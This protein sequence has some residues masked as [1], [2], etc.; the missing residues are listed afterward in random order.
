MRKSLCY[1]ALAFTLLVSQAAA[2]GQPDQT[3]PPGEAKSPDHTT[4]PTGAAQP[5]APLADQARPAVVGPAQAD[6][7]GSLPDSVPGATRQTMPSTVSAE[8]ALYDKLPIA[9]FRFL[10]TSE[11]RNF[12]AESVGKQP[13]GSGKLDVS[14][15][16]ELPGSVAL[17][18]FPDEVT[19]K[20]PG[21]EKFKYVK[22]PDRVLIV[23]PP[24]RIVVGEIS[25]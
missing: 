6:T 13:N 2:Q 25:R 21:A 5:R 18:E 11:Q 3:A 7:A 10:V 4:P 20:V 9:A 22:T 15:S 14:V 23:D 19:A 12:I 17:Q 1:G 24:N 8:N 16:E